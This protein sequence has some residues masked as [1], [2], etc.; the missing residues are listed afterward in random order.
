[1]LVNER[2]VKDGEPDYLL[3]SSDEPER[4]EYAARPATPARAPEPVTVPDDD[5]PF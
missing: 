2:K 1:V 5:F 4:D 3:M